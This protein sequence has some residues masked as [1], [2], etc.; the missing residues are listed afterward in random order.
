MIPKNTIFLS[1]DKDAE[2]AARFYAATFPESR[3]KA[4]TKRLAISPAARRTKYLQSSFGYSLSR[5]Q[6]RTGVQAQRGL[7]LPDCD[8]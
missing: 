6:R 3:V 5:P 1:F 4:F 8:G 2:E 7:F